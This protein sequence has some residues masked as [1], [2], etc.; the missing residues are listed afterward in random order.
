MRE[1]AILDAISVCEENDAVYR[2][3]GMRFMSKARNSQEVF[4]HHDF[5]ALHFLYQALQVT[6]RL[7]CGDLSG[8]VTAT[9]REY[10]GI[11]TKIISLSK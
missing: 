11:V 7:V 4:D 9:S 6:A 2:D 8:T 1:N 10:E 5:S 3:H